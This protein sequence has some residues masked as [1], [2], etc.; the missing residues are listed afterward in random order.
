VFICRQLVADTVGFGRNIDF[1]GCGRS[2]LVIRT[3]LSNNECDELEH[4]RASISGKE[5]F[6]IYLL[7][8]I[9]DNVL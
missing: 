7:V 8:T 1:T 6:T 5:I 3:I 4:P 9:C 2:D